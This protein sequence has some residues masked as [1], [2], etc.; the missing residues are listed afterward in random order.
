MTYIRALMSSKF[1]QIRSGTTEKGRVRTS[2]CFFG[3]DQLSQNLRQTIC[4]HAKQRIV[5]KELRQRI[6]V[7]VFT[8]L[9]CS[10]EL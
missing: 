5:L 8:L 7:N 4:V 9:L 6:F 2:I 10:H 1:G 3:K